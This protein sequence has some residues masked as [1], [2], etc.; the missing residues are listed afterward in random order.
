M[1]QMT[2]RE[3]QVKVLVLLIF[4]CRVLVGQSAKVP[5]GV[6]GRWLICSTAAVSGPGSYTTWNRNPLGKIIEYSAGAEVYDGNRFSLKGY[7]KYSYA[8]PLEFESLNGIPTRNL[9][10]HTPQLSYTPEREAGPTED[11]VDAEILPIAPDQ[12]LINWKGWLLRAR[13]AS[14]GCNVKK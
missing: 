3:H 8:T 11:I 2:P 7:E 4:L 1:R 9:G 14:I 12:L 6:S 10:L 13:P 5:A